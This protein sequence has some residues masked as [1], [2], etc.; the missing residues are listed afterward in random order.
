MK[1]ARSLR[2]RLV[3]G[4][5]FWSVG[6]VFVLNL[7]ITILR[8]FPGG[9]MHIG[10]M[11]VAA[12]GLLVFGLVQ[13]RG[14]L[15]LFRRLQV[16]LTAVREGRAPRLEGRYPSEVQPLVT[17][18]NDLLDDRDQAVRRAVAKAGDLAHG[19]KTPLA[20]LAQEAER[21]SGAGQRDAGTVIAQQVDR[22]RRHVDYHLAHAR[23]SAFGATPGTSSLVLESVDGLARTVSRLYEAKHIAFD[24]V[25]A[26]EHRVRV[27]RHDL[28]E[29]L[30]N[31][32]DNAWKWARSRVTVRSAQE[33]GRISV[34][35]D[36]DGPGIPE[37][38]RQRVLRR[39]VR[40]D[41]ASPGT[42]LGLAIVADL[43]DLYGGAV[44][45]DASP[46]GGARACL[47]L[48]SCD[49]PFAAR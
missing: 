9:V 47:T 18:L 46:A 19:L 1:A 28:D 12:A 13:I 4:A 7:V 34:L 16:R 29:M 27:H 11:T 49:R 48:P 14:I 3:I 10:G 39:G 17:D 44:S 45:L 36:D 21:L 15:A 24:V 31:L 32:F 40:V 2:A 37:D 42:G 5:I 23:A 38:M 30:G 41:E 22:M 8:R 25:V 20:I 33:R 35:I 26:P 43:A 6:L